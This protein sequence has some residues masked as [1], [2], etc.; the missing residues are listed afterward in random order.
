[1]A[2]QLTIGPDAINS[3]KRLAY[4]PWHALA[5]FIDN[6]TQAY[7]DNKDLL[8]KSFKESN[9]ILEVA[10]VYDK[11]AGL[12]RISD[13]SI[14]LSLNDLER[15]L[16]VALPPAN[17]KGRSKYGMG[18]KTAACWLGNRWTIQTKKLGETVEH[19]A[20]IVVE[21]IAAGKSDLEY[22]AISN[23][24]AAKHYTIIEIRELNRPFHG[25][26]IKK[27]RDF[28]SSMYREDFRN[29]SLKLMWD[30]VPLQWREL[31]DR[32]LKDAEGN[33]YKRPFSFVVDGKKI[34]G[35]V[36]I[37]ERGSRADAGFSIIHCGRVVR[38]YPDSWRP[39]SLYGQLQGSNDLVNQR[40]VGEIHLDDFD[41]SHTKDDILWLG[42][43]EEDVEKEL[44]E[45]CADYK[46]RANAL[47]KNKDDERG[48]SE[49]E[50]IAAI[51]ELKKELTSPEMIDAIELQTVP[52]PDVVASQAKNIAEAISKFEDTFSAVIGQLRVRGFLRPDMSP[53]DP[54]VTHDSAKENE[55]LIIIN[56]AHPHWLQLKGSDGVL[57]YLRH[58]VYD[59]IAEWKAKHKAAALNPDTIKVLKDQLLRVPF[60]IEMHPHSRKN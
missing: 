50:T 19:H 37:L 33:L 24:P 60:E 45:H 18:L 58:C 22:K 44:G 7:F 40:L 9:E 28:L 52:S 2:L 16:H 53:N 56:Q 35:W 23:R 31:D 55:V 54:Y 11:D 59:G 51:D 8:D 13:N 57:N 5:E 21:K 12:L 6:S 48:P 27:I 30:G 29:E 42:S 47:R 41:V 10:V 14:G 34:H 49:L 36:G 26:T 32:L 17:T 46:A 15:A 43:Q 1:M 39:A 20:S 3:Y 25:R 38:G 4:T